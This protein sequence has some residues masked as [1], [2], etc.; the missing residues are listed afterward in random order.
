M[1]SAFFRDRTDAVLEVIGTTSVPATVASKTVEPA[2]V[3]LFTGHM[4]DNRGR[5]APRFP[6]DMQPK[7]REAI[8]E[9]VLN[10]KSLT[11]G[12]LLGMSGASNGGDILFHEACQENSIETQ[13]YLAL[14]EQQYI[15]QSVAPA[16]GDWVERFWKV[17]NASAKVR[18]LQQSEEL[19]FWLRSMRNYSVWQRNN[20]WLLYNALA[21]HVDTTLIA[22]WNGARADAPGGTQDMIAT[23]QAKGVKVVILDTR[24]LFGLA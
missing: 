24:R 5:E 9:A 22:L 17:R 6:P 7:A 15:A 23:A 21:L 3:I 14:P 13:V 20:L 1:I 12:N 4:I 16:D 18:V 10:E 11:E 19:P 2:R 8:L